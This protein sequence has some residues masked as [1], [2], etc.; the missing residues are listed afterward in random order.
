MRYLCIF[1]LGI[2]CGCSNTPTPSLSVRTIYSSAGQLASVEENTPDPIKP[3][4]GKKQILLVR[5]SCPHIETP[6]LNIYYHFKDQTLLQETKQLPG[7]SGE[8]GLEIPR[9]QLRKHG[10]L[11]SYKIVLMH[12]NEELAHSQHK[13]WVPMIEIEEESISDDDFS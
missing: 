6:T 3:L 1:L 13:M 4:L 10:T 7:S 2:L 9:Q 11:N 5:W 12:N 8:I